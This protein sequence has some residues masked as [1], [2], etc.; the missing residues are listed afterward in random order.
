MVVRFLRMASSDTDP[1]DDD[2]ASSA[3]VTSDD[4]R[5]SSDDALL[6]TVAA[7]TEVTLPQP[8]IELGL[9]E[10]SSIPPRSVYGDERVT[11]EHP[12]RYQIEG[13]LGAGGI[14]R[15]Y[16][17]L[18]NHLGRHI[19][20]KELL[21]EGEP[22]GGRTT[23]R[24][25]VELRFLNEARITGQLEHPGIVPV[26][27]LGRRADDTLYYTMRYV[28]G[29][30]LE[31]ALKE[32][33]LQK[34]LELLTHFI[35][36][37]NT[38]AY[39]HARGVIHRDL[40]P[41]NVMLGDFGET[42]VLDW[43]LAKRRGE[44]DLQGTVLRAELERMMSAPAL[45]TV[46]GLPLGTPGYM[47]PEQA[48]G[49]LDHVDERSDVYSLGVIL[50]Q[51]LTGRLPF[52]GD[53]GREVIQQLVRN[54]APRATEL[55]PECPKEL[56][57]IAARALAK[58]HLER[59]PDAGALAADVKAFM[60][61]GLVGAHEYSPR[62][63][64]MRWLRAN[65]LQLAGAAAIVLVAALT[66]WYRG[67]EVGLVRARA[68]QKHRDN[69]AAEIMAVYR[70]VAEGD[71]EARW[72]DLR[73]FHIIGMRDRVSEETV[74]DKLVEGLSHPSPDVRRLAARSTS[75][76]KS[77][78]VVDALIAR[79]APDVEPT[80]EVAIEIIN[81]LGV[82]RDPRAES[83]VSEARHRAGQYSNLW[84]ETELAY[85]MIPLGPPAGELD[86]NG[87]N[88]RGNA[89][90]WKQRFD[91]AL[92]AYGKAIAMAPDDPRPYNNRAIV[93]RRIGDL[94]GALADY[95]KVVALQPDVI[96]AYN[97]RALLRRI[98]GDH[99]GALADLDRVVADGSFGVTALRN[100]SL[101]KRHMGDFEGAHADLQAALALAPDDARTH[102][103]IGSTW[104]WT[105]D[106]SQALTALDQ[107]VALNAAYSFAILQRAK[108]RI[109]V[110]RRDEARADIDR[111]L[112]LDPAEN[113][114]R[115]MRASLFMDEGKYDEARRDLDYCLEN[116]CIREES[117]RAL[118]HAQRG[119]VYH[120]ARR[121]WDAALEDLRVALASR[122]RQVDAFTFQLAG[123]AIALRSGD[124][125][126]A[127]R[128]KAALAA[129]PAADAWYAPLAER[130]SVKTDEALSSWHA[131]HHAR[132]FQP[133][134]RCA[135]GLTAG[136]LAEAE[137]D[138]AAALGYYR[139]A[140]ET[141]DPYDLACLLAKQAI[142]ALER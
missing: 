101:V 68:E 45:K 36:L 72:L 85:R 127:G 26:Y 124:A 77:P 17:A 95:D 56:A 32:P 6:T 73:S 47:S 16:V 55:E 37:C 142:A 114:A 44:Q 2:V 33:S 35:D 110:G 111:V 136:L 5:V 59:Y 19:A 76:F 139:K 41:E 84:T 4:K 8:R 57:A 14:G 119:V 90:M 24:S 128:W 64:A 74:I 49:E 91:E 31:D 120:A 123:Y 20:L 125:A 63:L 130:P 103:A 141:G 22:S 52:D 71:L 34:R 108:V 137:G 7:A 116:Q 87:W 43:G 3:I 113:W 94:Q 82:L 51:L 13:E 88:V 30:T 107:A 121:E 93:R 115:R 39:A 81:A 135:V 75:A 132:L 12:G 25:P 11:D 48:L 15:V 42:V 80:P 96:Y 61:G 1:R 109:L 112:Q 53:S 21:D 102:A 27:E 50:F 97:N 69:V 67:V 38:V 99:A 60:T 83:A 129:M 118:R 104:V 105:G 79:L 100:R 66:W 23:I 62:A 78:R 122:P 29:R 131:R 92:E 58:D 10:L 40:K 98:M 86:V 106:W 126:E 28:K 9:S 134:Q 140:G 46:A 65:K 133:L 54:P 18:D 138:A 117:R 89:L 70:E